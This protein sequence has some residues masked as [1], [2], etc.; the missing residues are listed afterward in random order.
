MTNEMFISIVFAFKSYAIQ[1]LLSFIIPNN[2]KS[3]LQY[4]YRIYISYLQKVLFDANSPL[5][6]RG[7]IL[8]S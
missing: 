2:H 7:V 1:P 6:L 5:I 3:Y 8:T 4:Q